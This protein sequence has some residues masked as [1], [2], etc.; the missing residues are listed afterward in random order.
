MANLNDP[1]YWKQAGRVVIDKL[2]RGFL[3]LY[4]QIIRNIKRS[5]RVVLLGGK[6]LL[7]VSRHFGELLVFSQK[8]G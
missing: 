7:P 6:A 4:P 8:H 3:A 2:F 5:N 1:S